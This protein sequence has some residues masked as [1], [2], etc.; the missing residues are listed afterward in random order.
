MGDA[1]LARTSRARSR[2]AARRRDRRRDG[3]VGDADHQLL[4]RPHRRIDGLRQTGARHHLAGVARNRASGRDAEVFA[5]GAARRVDQSAAHFREGDDGFLFHH[6]AEIASRRSEAAR[7]LPGLRSRSR[8]VDGGSRSD[9]RPLPS[10]LDRAPPPGFRAQD[11]GQRRL[12]RRLGLLRRRDVI[13]TWPVRRGP[14]RAARHRAVGTDPRRTRDRRRR[15]RQRQL[16]VPARGNLLCAR[17]RC[18]P[19]SSRRGRRRHRAGSR[20]RDLLHRRS[21][22]T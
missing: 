18:D 8:L 2:D 9:A 14:G 10:I 5:T 22:S 21:V 17:N 16:D 19:R 3:P 4:S 6:A 20:G 12:L 7:P 1:N 15:A 11:F 13:A